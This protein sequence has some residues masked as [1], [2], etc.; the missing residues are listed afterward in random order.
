MT[1]LENLLTRRSAILAELAA[2]PSKPNYTV[3]GQSVAW[4]EYRRSLLDELTMLN[5][6]IAVAEG[7]WEIETRGTT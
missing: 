3:D 6:Q 1:D 4:N 7:P 2:G 5:A